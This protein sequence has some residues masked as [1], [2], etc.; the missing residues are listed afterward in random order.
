MGEEVVTV[1]RSLHTDVEVSTQGDETPLIPQGFYVPE[2]Y[3]L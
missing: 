3:S 1:L 2:G